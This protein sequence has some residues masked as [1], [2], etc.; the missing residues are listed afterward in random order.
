[1][2]TMKVFKQVIKTL[3]LSWRFNQMR[4]IQ[5]RVVS[6]QVESGSRPATRVEESKGTFERKTAPTLM[7]ALYPWRV[8][9]FREVRV[10][11]PSDEFRK[12]CWVYG[13]TKRAADPLSVTGYRSVLQTYV[14]RI[15]TCF[16]ISGRLKDFI[17]FL[18]KN[19]RWAAG[20]RPVAHSK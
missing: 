1:M 3:G 20:R 17:S 10:A 18:G 13:L 16:P 4:T 8:A 6:P 11:L 19:A 14:W 9:W 7:N 5:H 2:L 12:Q 15:T